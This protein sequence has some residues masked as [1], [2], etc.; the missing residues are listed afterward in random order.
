MRVF[1]TLF[2]FSLVPILL[3]PFIPSTWQRRWWIVSALLPMLIGGI[4]LFVEGWRIQMA[5]LYI[6]ALLAL[7]Y[8]LTALFGREGIGFRK[9]EILMSSVMALFL[10][11]SGV[12]AGWLLP[13]VRLPQPTGPYHV[14]IV[15]REIVDRAQGRRL[16]VSIW[17]P[18]AQS[19]TS[20]P[21]THHPDEVATGLGKIAGLP[22]LPFQHLRYFT[23]AAS[24]SVSPLAE[25]APFPVLVFSHGLVGL[26]LQNSS[27]LQDLASWGYVVVALDHTDAAAVTV[28]PDGETRFYNLERFGIPSNVEPDKTLVN[29]RV[30]PVWVADQRLIYDMLETWAVN[31]PLLAGKLDV[32]RIGSFGHSFGGATALEVC[33]I[34]ARCRAAANMDGGLYGLIVTEPADRPLLLM[35]SAESNQYS[36]TVEE[37]TRMVEN[38]NAD[39]YW[40]ELPGSTHFSFTITQLLSPILV[41][42]DFDPRAGLHIVDTYLRTFFD[43]HLR[44]IRTL[45]VEP[46]PREA[47]VRWFTRA[48]LYPFQK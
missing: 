7:V 36:E 31:D 37:W 20:A 44:G 41:P 33:R 34:D 9:R 48:R 35:S 8:R 28:F 19:S 42:K 25:G 24:N 5:P 17:Y 32:T 27:T 39:A 45:P 30:F 22:G 16:M 4:H 21:L 38:A 10:T 40:L 15:D 46:A 29:E 6:L 18:A 14:G 47:D 23:L 2:L 11:L 12:L 43:L 13:V 3:I 1:E 26:R